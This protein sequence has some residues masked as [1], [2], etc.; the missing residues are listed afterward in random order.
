LGPRVLT[1]SEKKLREA[2]LRTATDSIPA[3]P[4][5]TPIQQCDPNFAAFQDRDFEPRP[6]G[7]NSVYEASAELRFPVWE[8]LSGAVFVDMG[9]VSQKTDPTLPGSKSAITPGFG[10]RYKSPVGPIRVDLGVNPAKRE[11]LPVIT[12]TVVDGERR[13]VRLEQRRAYSIARSGLSGILDRL[14]LHLSIGE[15]F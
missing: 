1:I 9:F 2:H 4:E 13:L 15:A 6:L 7:G 11:D 8:Q 12:E 5:L 10:A 14:V 3:C